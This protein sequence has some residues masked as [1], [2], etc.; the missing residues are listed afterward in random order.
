[1]S[2]IFYKDNPYGGTTTVTDA[3]HV[4]VTEGSDTTTAQAKFN[5]QT[6]AIQRILGNFATVEQST[7]ASKA[8]NVGDYL[9]LN[10]FLYK[11]TQAIAAGG[12][13]DNTQNGNVEKTS[14][15]AEFG[16]GG[17]IELTQAQYDA[18]SEEEKMDDVIYL[19]TDSPDNYLDEVFG[20]F[21]TVEYTNTASKSYSGGDHLVFNSKLYRVTSGFAQG[22]TIIPGTNVVETTVSDEIQPILMMADTAPSATSSLLDVL[23]SKWL[24]QIPAD[25]LPRMVRV[26]YV[27]GGAFYG[28]LNRYVSG[29]K[30][31]GSGLLTKYDGTFCKANI[32]ADTV[33]VNQIPTSSEI[34]VYLG[35]IGTYTGDYKAALKAA[36]ADISL[37]D[38]VCSGIFS[39][40]GIWMFI[41]YKY[42]G[43]QYGMMLA[44]HYYTG[45]NI[46]V[47][48]RVSGV[49]TIR[50]LTTTTV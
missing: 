36:F 18:L 47:L 20:D 32:V 40:N 39:N 33:T 41:A 25:T 29:G 19:I 27:T 1:M 50:A 15:G 7:T 49:D 21:A 44:I 13:I 26:D 2:A 34:T 6:T 30:S 31:Y 3:G 5:T 45:T 22:A 4:L 43:S 38:R 23:Q 46:C 17:T 24:T 10:S 14:A 12:T 35:N 28:Y 16:S 8:Y 37:F 42:T 48:T 9:V 11:V